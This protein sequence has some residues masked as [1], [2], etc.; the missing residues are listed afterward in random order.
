MKAPRTKTRLLAL[1]SLAI[2]SLMT[3]AMFSTVSAATIINKHFEGKGAIAQ[4][5]INTPAGPHTIDA[6][7]DMT[8][9]EK[10]PEIYVS[11]SH[12][13]RGVSAGAG[14]AN[15]TWSTNHVTVEAVVTF[16]V[17][18]SGSSPGRTGSHSIS[19]TWRT[20]GPTSNKPLTVNTMNGLTALIDGAL[21]HGK[22]ELTLDLTATSGHHQDDVFT[23]SWAIVMHGTAD[24]T[25]TS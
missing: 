11:I 2:I 16:A 24:I 18:V 25:L 19:I 21:K 13:S 4:W 6:I 8:N 9:S 3:T 7:V 22:A 5:I 15:V 12:P 20:D 1:L 23:S 14:S 10:N 17:V